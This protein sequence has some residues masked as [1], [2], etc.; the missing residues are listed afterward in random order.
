LL[1]APQSSVVA[2]SA[3]WLARD[4]VV[5]QN[6]RPIGQSHAPFVHVPG[7]CAPHAPQFLGSRWRSTH[8]RDAVPEIAQTP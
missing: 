4:E 6:V 7:H 5:A 2:R 1:H 3:Q 8:T